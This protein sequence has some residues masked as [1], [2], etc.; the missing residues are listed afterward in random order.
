MRYDKNLP[1]QKSEDKKIEWYDFENLELIIAGV[2]CIC[3]T[4]MSN[5]EVTMQT[6]LFK[7]DKD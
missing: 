3:T 7:C 2:G 6:L 4:L 5:N 1:N